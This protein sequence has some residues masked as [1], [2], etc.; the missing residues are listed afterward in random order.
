[1]ELQRQGLTALPPKSGEQLRLQDPIF[2]GLS[3]YYSSKFLLLT[4]SEYLSITA[5]QE[6]FRILQQKIAL[7]AYLLSH[8]EVVKIKDV[9]KVYYHF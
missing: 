5:K 7:A 3:K 9:I 8:L 6:E 2:S 1:M 4:E